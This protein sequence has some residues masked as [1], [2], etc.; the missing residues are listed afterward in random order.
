[1]NQ[2]LGKNILI[3]GASYGLGK[4]VAQKFWVLGANLFLVAR[5]KNIL[6]T[7][8][9]ELNSQAKN[10]QS[11]FFLALDLTKSN[12]I[13]KI[14]TFLENQH[15][16]V[17]IL[18]NNAAIQGPI[19]QFWDN[20]WQDWQNTLQTDLLSPVELCRICVPGMIKKKSGKIINLS[21]GGA[22][23][24]RPNFSAYAV[25]KTGLI[26]FSEILAQ[27]LLSFN[28]DVNCIAPGVMNSKLLSN[29][30]EAGPV[31][32]GT[33]E[34]TI[35]Q[36]SQNDHNNTIERAAN[37]CVYLASSKSNGITGKL[38]SAVWDPWETLYEKKEELA[39]SDIY[40]LR[41]IVPKDRNQNWGDK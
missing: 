34:Y 14:K 12:S 39:K 13:N 38:I 5:S 37:L 10:K 31:I 3:T 9:K 27:E 22:T 30:L 26:R 29:V 21:G 19:G 7:F 8:C 6:E 35:A 4:L 36:N 33:K 15:Y 28:I 20:N 25:A 18:I 2:F 11:A 23:G 32:A 17:D 16:S 41:R 40:T 24:P 1:M